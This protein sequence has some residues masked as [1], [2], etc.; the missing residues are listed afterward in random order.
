MN[1]ANLLRHALHAAHAIVNNEP[2]GPILAE[3]L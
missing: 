2:F 3:G 1:E